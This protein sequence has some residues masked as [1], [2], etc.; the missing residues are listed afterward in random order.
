MKDHVDMIIGGEAGQG[1]VTIGEILSKSLVRAGY[2]IVVNQGYQSR[3]RGGHNTFMISVSPNPISAP[4]PEPYSK[5][6]DICIALDETTALQAANNLKSDGLLIYD[7]KFGNMDWARSLKIPYKEIATGIYENTAAFGIIASILGLDPS[8]ATE[9]INQTFS[10][11]PESIEANSK[12]LMNAFK[13]IENQIAINDLAN[14]RLVPCD[15]RVSRLMLNGNEAIALGA[16]AAGL[17]FYS[18][19]PMTPSTSIALTIASYANRMGIVIEQAEDEISAINMAIGASYA[20]AP[21][22]VGT[23]GGGFA[24]MVEGVSLAAMTETPIVIALA[25]RPG[26]ATGMPTRTEQADLEYA[27][28]SGHGEFPRALYAPSSIEECFY[29][30]AKAFQLAEKYQSP[31]FILTD[32]FLADSFRSVDALNLDE[33]QQ[34]YPGSDPSDVQ[35]PYLRYRITDDGVSPRL[36]PGTSKHLVVVDSDEHTEDGHLTEDEVDHV[37]CIKKDGKKEYLSIRRKMVEKRL[38]KL[39][40]LR[41]EV[42]HPIYIG[43]HSPDVLMVSWGSTRGAVEEAVKQLRQ[44]GVTSAML[45][46]TQVWP[47]I[48]ES[49]VDYLQAAKSVVSVEGNATGQLTNLIRRETGFLINKSILRYDGL[50]ITQRYILEEM[51]GLV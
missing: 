26:P 1:L 3:I 22:M 43:D 42:I 6:F 30:T 14:N 28:H 32:Q 2:H 44:S 17:R 10:R 31:V 12:A 23:S 16:I 18:F 41:N 47:L 48:P 11:H 51:D 50:P 35:V 21:A 34:V 29:L 9:V 33:V 8:L 39:E 15:A 27:L 5:E 49:F 24:L 36:I 13:W 19:Y 4:P 40:G 37:S 38:R 45:H 20:G 46:F 7:E 25:Q